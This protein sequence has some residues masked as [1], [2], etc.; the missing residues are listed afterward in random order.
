MA[1]KTK[2][3]LE[4]KISN[5]TYNNIIQDVYN[6]IQDN[7]ELK[8]NWSDFVSSDAGRMMTELFAWVGERLAERIDSVGNELF[9]ET[10][11]DKESVLRILKLV[12]YKLPLSTSATLPCKLS[13]STATPGTSIIESQLTL[14]NGAGSGNSVVLSSN[15]FKSF[16]HSA[17]GKTFEL[18]RY[19]E[20]TR[21]YEYFFPIIIKTLGDN[22]ENLQEGKTK[23]KN[24][25]VN[26]LGHYV[27]SLDNSVIM[28]SVSI[29][30]ST[31]NVGESFND[32]ELLK[33]DNFFCKEAQNSDRPVYKVNN[34]GGGV[35]EIEF[36]NLEINLKSNTKIGEEYTILYRVGGGSGGNISTRSLKS[37]EIITLNNGRTRGMITLENISGGYGGTD[38]PT[39]DEIR[40]QAPQDVRNYTSA[41]TAEDYEY[42][43][44]KNNDL[45]KDIKV[46]GESNITSEEIENAYGVYSSPLD[47][48]IFT[49]KQNKLFDNTTSNKLTKYI[50][51]ICFEIFDLNERLNEVYQFNTADLNVLIDT[52]TLF[53]LTTPIT[54]GSKDGIK[55]IHNPITIISTSSV[56]ENIETAEESDG[57]KVILTEEAF[58]EQKSNIIPNTSN[59]K[60]FIEDEDEKYPSGST[61]PKRFL[62]TGTDI[63]IEKIFPNF[64]VPFGLDTI[65]T[66]SGDEIS[67]KIGS[68]EE[69]TTLFSEASITPNEIVEQINNS[70]SYSINNTLQGILLKDD[71]VAKDGIVA[72]TITTGSAINFILNDSIESDTSCSFTISDTDFT[73]EDLVVKIN[74]ALNARF[75]ASNTYFASLVEKNVE[76]EPTCF[77]LVVY[78]SL[79]ENNKFS[80]KD[81]SDVK[82]LKTLLDRQETELSSSSIFYQAKEKNIITI[83][84][85]PTSYGTI[86]VAGIEINITE[87][88]TT[89][90]LVADK[91][92]DTFVDSDI[93]KVEKDA[94]V[95]ET[96]IFEAVEFGDIE[97]VVFIDTDSTG[98]EISIDLSEKDNEIIPIVEYFRYD[99]TPNSR[100]LS[101]IGAEK[102]EAIQIRN[103]RFFKD[104]FGLSDGDF[105]GGVWFYISGERILTFDGNFNYV[106]G[107][108]TIKSKLPNPLYASGFWGTE[109]KVELGSYYTNIKQNTSLPAEILPLLER[110]PIKKL[111]NTVYKQESHSSV[112]D[113]ADIY[114]SNH[115]VKF[116]RRKVGEYTFHQIGES[117]SPPM[118]KFAIKELG[119]SVPSDRVLKMRIN[120]E[121]LDIDGIVDGSVVSLTIDN[122]EI[123]EAAMYKT[124]YVYI[125][126]SKLKNITTRKIA[127]AI[128]SKFFSGKLMVLTE[129]ITDLPYFQTINNNYSS[130][131]DITG[132]SKE[133]FV[134]FFSGEFINVISSETS[135]IDVK[136][137]EYKKISFSKINHVPNKKIEITWSNGGSNTQKEIINT[138][139]SFENFKSGFSVFGD[140]MIFNGEELVFLPRLKDYTFKISA[141]IDEASEN[142]KFINQNI[143]ESFI[144]SL[145]NIPPVNGIVSLEQKNEGDYF[146]DANLTTGKY[147]L[148]IENLPAFPYGDIY[149]HMIED[150]RKDHEISTNINGDITYTDEYKWNQSIDSKKMICVNHVYKQPR[151]IPFDLEISASLMREAGLKKETEYIG[152]I[153]DFVRSVYNVYDGKIGKSI[154]KNTISLLI[155]DNVNYVKD[156]FVKYLGTDLEK[157][158]KNV[159]TLDIAFNEKAILASNER[160]KTINGTQEIINYIHGIKINLEYER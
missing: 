156:V 139:T 120:G 98:I 71:I 72:T 5:I 48:W 147:I 47:V 141:E 66:V 87:D 65:N 11:D 32:V 135:I 153:E 82:F 110:S 6:L 133:T 42:I 30:K 7:N 136:P 35:C 115:V 125:Y 144:P 85:P 123:M 102:G 67:I 140:K 41:I 79:T 158:I 103:T 149:T 56:K 127:D 106:V 18:I 160:T 76:A 126:M 101:I 77:S 52:K 15:S 88:I 16:T 17:S 19:N 13:I 51:D 100:K 45:I 152:L 150:Y 36:P 68:G 154:D 146:I 122:V 62:G 63:I 104:L 114:N 8:D 64:S 46:Y 89:K 145:K 74:E 132:T 49:I 43:L 83:T 34:L 57:F 54:I 75:T 108:T 143:L 105:E 155:Q 159:S 10:A 2:R 73:W 129:N 84:S 9:L 118:L 96:L 151:F 90:E 14:S 31:K 33:V 28:N 55:E 109:S 111:Y 94:T 128:V 81:S 4:T 91:I 23:F 50:N 61:T 131:I 116:T 44:K 92:V 38:E 124:G 112:S 137:I 78:N 86:E 3:P 26:R 1:I 113:V 27:I 22:F 80:I 58:E 95:S 40:E 117:E 130:S 119:N 97:Y 29:F 121:N 107:M 60:Y 59:I 157:Y 93:W 24:F 25:T 134:D 148:N 70:I 99:F 21:K 53:P 20:S 138:S 69:I 39:I 37:M 12:G 142:G